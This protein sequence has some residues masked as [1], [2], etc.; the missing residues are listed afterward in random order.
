VSPRDGEHEDPSTEQAALDEV[1]PNRLLAG[2]DEATQHLDDA[3]HWIKVYTEL[4]DFKRRILNTTEESVETMDPDA[5]QEVTDTDLKALNAEAL[6]FDRR[7]AYWRRR[8]A[9]MGSHE[10]EQH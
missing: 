9:A 6:R 1:E 2:E 7:L 4:L 3:H 8:A 10:G 5:S